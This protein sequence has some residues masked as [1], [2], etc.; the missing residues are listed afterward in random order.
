MGGSSSRP[1]SDSV[2]ALPESSVASSDAK[3]NG[4]DESPV[5][6]DPDEATSE[7]MTSIVPTASSSALSDVAVTDSVFPS[8]DSTIDQMQ[9]DSQVSQQFVI[10]MTSSTSDPAGSTPEVGLTNEQQPGKLQTSGKRMQF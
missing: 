4:A 1:S 5:N 2:P 7:P 3:D 9:L 10:D 8:L 6:E